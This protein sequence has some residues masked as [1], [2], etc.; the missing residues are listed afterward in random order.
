L[1]RRLRIGY[2]RAARII[3]ALEEEGIIG[4]DQGGSRG[5]DVLITDSP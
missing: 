3:E 1:Q 2:A 5:R 4:P